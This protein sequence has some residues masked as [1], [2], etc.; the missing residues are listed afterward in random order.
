MASVKT[1]A[2]PAGLD[3]HCYRLTDK[4][5]AC[6]QVVAGNKG[7]T[8]GSL[9]RYMHDVLFL[10]GSGTWFDQLRQFVPPRSLEETLQALLALDLIEVAD[11]TE[12]A[13]RTRP[14]VARRADRLRFHT[15]PP[16]AFTTS[17]SSGSMY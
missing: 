1:P 14:E 8:I 15:H 17:Q 3:S 16:L 13:R 2:P 5:R 10:C 9:S 7:Q 11:G 12:L 4:G 6:V